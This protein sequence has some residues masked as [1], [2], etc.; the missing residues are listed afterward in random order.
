MLKGL[1]RPDFK[2]EQFEAL[3]YRILVELDPIEE[4]TS[5]G[6]ILIARDDLTSNTE[7]QAMNLGTVVDIGPLAFNPHGGPEAWARKGLKAGDRVWVPS[8]GGEYIPPFKDDP[9]NH[10]G[11]M[12]IEDE[13]VAVRIKPLKKEKK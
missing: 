5:E 11:Y 9:K 13:K 8:Y 1:E 10:S 2:K 6:G 4:K 3:G 7:K 12:L